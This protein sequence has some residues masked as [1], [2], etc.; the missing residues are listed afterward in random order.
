MNKKIS[1]I[2]I[3]IIFLMFVKVISSYA[4]EGCGS[5]HDCQN[6]HSFNK[7]E[8]KQVLGK[9]IPDLKI[10]EVK[11]APVNG[12]WEIAIESKE[13]KK[14]ILY[15]DFSKKNVIIGRIINI[16]TKEDLTMKR[17][18]E[19]DKV[20][21][22]K[23]PLKN[24]LV[25]GNSNAKH[26]VVIFTDP[27]C[28]F[29]AKLHKEIKKIL[30]KR[31]DI[32]FYIKLFPLKFL[33]KDA[34]RKAKAIQCNKSIKMLDD[35][36][37]RKSIPDPKCDTDVIDKNIKLAIKLGIRGTPSIVLEDGRI[38]RGFRKAEQLLQY[39]DNSNKKGS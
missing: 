19:I 30:K 26:K 12:L 15:L 13:G 6:C 18:I 4:T 25:M 27:E 9:F 20:D 22:S 3:G 16:N 32:A 37:E 10:L 8:A 17:F 14:G 23:I 1:K 21:F 28:P 36:F 11:K 5:V 39:I 31:N 35:A 2:T 7:K 29:C 33:H 34:Y 24:A 38:I